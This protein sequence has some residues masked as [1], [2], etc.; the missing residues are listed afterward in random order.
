MAT[1]EHNPP[2]STPPRAL[3]NGW[4]RITESSPVRD[5]GPRTMDYERCAALH[6]EL[7]TR[8]VNGHGSQMPSN[9]QTWWEARGP[10]EEVANSLHPSLIEFLKRAWDEDVLP[11]YFRLFAFVGGL[12]SP[13]NLRD[14]HS[15]WHEEEDEEG[16]LVKLYES[17][18][19]R[20][21]DDEGILYGLIPSSYPTT[22]LE[23][24]RTDFY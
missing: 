1:S 5:L 12:R 20:V 19:Y 17:S 22:D 8:A 11:P 15:I 24:R 14:R 7:L 21:A 4:P 16:R 13:N 3:P 9:P 23:A 2:S 6:N 10:S 18:H